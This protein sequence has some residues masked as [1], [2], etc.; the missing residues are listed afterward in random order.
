MDRL[1]KVKAI[2]RDDWNPLGINADEL[3]DE[4]DSYAPAILKRLENDSPAC[5][6]VKYLLGAEVADM[7]L[8]PN[9]DRAYRVAALLKQLTG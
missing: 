9:E 6:I 8:T 2:L 4:Y 3:P 1:E 7:N 5:R